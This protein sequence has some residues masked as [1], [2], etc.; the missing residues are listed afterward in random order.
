MLRLLRHSQINYQDF[1]NATDTNGNCGKT[2]M[3]TYK[4]KTVNGYVA[5]KVRCSR[6]SVKPTIRYERMFQCEECGSRE[7]AISLALFKALGGE[8][9]TQSD[10]YIL[11]DGQWS[12]SS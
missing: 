9:Y 1:K 7:I 6:P 3:L 11:K 8:H 5:D 12:Y 2:V 10:S 4:G